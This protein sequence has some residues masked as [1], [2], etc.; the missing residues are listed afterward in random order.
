MDMVRIWGVKCCSERGQMKELFVGLRSVSLFLLKHVFVCLLHCAE[1]E[2]VILRVQ[3]RPTPEFTEYV[4]RVSNSFLLIVC[5]I[6]RQFTVKL[7]WERLCTTYEK[8][9]KR[10]SSAV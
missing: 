10:G 6:M 3:R 1:Y 9:L 4:R 2:D 5:R 7:N 8:I